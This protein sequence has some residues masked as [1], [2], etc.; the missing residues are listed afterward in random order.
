MLDIKL[1]RQN[2]QNIKDKLLKKKFVFSVYDFKNLEQ[3][4]KQLQIETQNLQNEKNKSAKSIGKAKQQGEDIQPLLKEVEHLKT[5]LTNN[6]NELS[7]ILKKLH[8]LLSAVPNIPAE[9]V[10]IGDDEN[11]NVE[12]KKWGNIPKFDF[13]P[14]EHSEIA[15]DENMDFATAAAISSS[16]FVILKNEIA[17]LHRVL[18]QFMIDAHTDNNYTELYVPYIVNSKS[19]YGTGNLPKFADDLFKIKSDKEN[20]FYLIPTAEVPVTNI[21]ANKIIKDSD[22]PLKMVCHTPCFRS[23]AGSYGKDTSG[24]I[25]QHQ[26]EK[27]ELVQLSTPD[28][29]DE[30]LEN[31]TQNAMNILEKLNL[32]YRQV[33]LCGAD[34]GFSSK[35]TYDLEVWMPS[36]NTYREISSCSNFGDFQARRMMA[37]FKNENGNIEY[38]HTLNGSALAVGRTLAAIIENYQQQDG[39]IKIP[40]VLQKYFKNNKNN[41]IITNPSSKSAK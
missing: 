11:N 3:Q 37:R 28:N 5:Q 6:E 9:D 1:V 10:P 15:T 13:K 27:V 4:R 16:R 7:I 12:I 21:Y 20:D 36:Q 29:S 34:L 39:S 35:K 8:N 18:I 17:K 30:E 41:E 2:P 14:K 33:I 22:L 25:R 23:E 31:L 24:I 32:P 38:V 26:F 40:K 19:L